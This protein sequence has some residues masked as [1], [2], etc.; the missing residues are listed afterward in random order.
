MQ[1]VIGVLADRSKSRWGRRRPFMLAGC[2]VSVFAMMLL[3]WAR[4]VAGWVGGG[5]GVAIALAVWAIYLIDFVSGDNP[6][7]PDVSGRMLR[8]LWNSL[9]MRF[10]RRIGRWWSIFCRRLSRK[11]ET[12]GQVGC[13]G[14]VLSRDFT[15]EC[16]LGEFIVDHRLTLQTQGKHQPSRA[17]SHPRQDPAPGSQL[18]N[19]C[20]VDGDTWLDG[21]QCK[22]TRLAPR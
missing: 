10:K 3:A 2:V 5:N 9:S 1:P 15:C 18:F 22:G 7:C 16:G 11:R 19:K 6:R 14:R 20:Y 21:L 12:L 17:L 8:A 4:E 13:L